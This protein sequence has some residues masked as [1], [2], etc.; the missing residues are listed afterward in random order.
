MKKELHTE[1]NWVIVKGDQV[2]R[3]ETFNE[4]A[5]INTMLGGYLMSE[6][7]YEHHYKHEKDVTKFSDISDDWS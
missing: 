1:P 2:F 4:A 7:Y 3:Y 6:N 5:V